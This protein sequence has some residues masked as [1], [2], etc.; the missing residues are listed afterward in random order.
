MTSTLSNLQPTHKSLCGT[1]LDNA[2]SIHHLLPG[3]DLPTSCFNDVV[4]VPLASWLFYLFLIGAGVVVAV[5]ASRSSTGSGVLRTLTT[6]QQ[7]PMRVYYP[8][9]QKKKWAG[10]RLTGEIIYT[11]LIIAAILMSE[12]KPRAHV[13]TARGQLTLTLTYPL[14]TCPIRHPR[15]SASLHLQTKHTRRRTP[16]F[17]IPFH[18]TC[19]IPLPLATYKHHPLPRVHP[20]LL[21]APPHLHRCQVESLGRPGK[22]R[23]SGWDRV[24]Q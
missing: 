20:A 21:V 8:R 22:L 1:R 14:G 4:L 16:S 18:P 15:T 6:K 7:Q 2:I 10:L 23:K 3:Y 13:A 12:S 9:G 19:A 5:F 24:P 11:L 17:H